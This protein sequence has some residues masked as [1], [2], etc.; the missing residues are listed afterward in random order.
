MTV[1]SKYSE[2]RLDSGMVEQKATA[3]FSGWPLP[4]FLP[5]SAKPFQHPMTFAA[6][7]ISK[8]SSSAMARWYTS[9]TTSSETVSAMTR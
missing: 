1:R 8:P 4:S 3:F 2:M 7:V 9:L 6:S 5:W